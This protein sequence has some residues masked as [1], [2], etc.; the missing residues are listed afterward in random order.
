MDDAHV[1]AAMRTVSL[2]PVRACL[3]ARAADWPWSSVRAHLAGCDNSLV[4]VN[5]VL[6]RV[7][8]FA[9]LLAPD[10]ADEDRFAGVRRSESTGR[11]P[12]TPESVA[13]LEHLL[14]RPIAS[15]A[16]GRKPNSRDLDQQSLL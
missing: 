15:R 10:A 2:N 4:T 5:P 11:P 7:G 9:K 13:G 16:P 1:I 14:G 6:E 3:V 8:E 12:A